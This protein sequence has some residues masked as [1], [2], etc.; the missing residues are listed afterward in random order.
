L[1]KRAIFYKM[2]I[3][4]LISFDIIKS[5]TQGG[6][7]LNSERGMP[8]VETIISIASIIVTSISIYVALR[9]KKK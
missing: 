2:L 4:I 9:N 6:S 7:W 8:M 5:S 1:E 3:S